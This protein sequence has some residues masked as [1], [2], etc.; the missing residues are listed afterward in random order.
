M[1]LSTLSTADAVWL[2]VSPSFQRL[3]QKLLVRL[4]SHCS[5]N[6]WDYS[7]TPDEPCSLAI[8]LT[9]L[10]DYIKGCNRPLHLVGHSTGG[11]LGLLYA[12][13]FPKRVASLTLL[14]VGVNAA[15]DWKAHYYTQLEQLHCSRAR[16]LAQMVYVL[17]GHQPKHLLKRWVAVLEQD[18]VQSLSLHS[19]TKIFSLFPSGVPVPLLATGGSEDAIVDPTQ[20]QGWLPWLKPG[21]RTWLCPHGRHFFHDT[22]PKEVADEILSFWSTTSEPSVSCCPEPMDVCP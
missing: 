2:S 12:R 8:G 7:Q 21:D 11:L 6:R 10:H 4:A 13:K 3:D 15:V 5:V 9:L 17:L 20:L 18:L 22:H 16:V 19:L 1:T 14:S